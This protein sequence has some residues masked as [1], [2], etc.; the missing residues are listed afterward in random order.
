MFQRLMRRSNYI[1][2]NCNFSF[3]TKG[4]EAF[5]KE[6]FVDKSKS[7]VKKGCHPTISV[8]TDKDWKIKEL[9]KKELEKEGVVSK[10]T[11]WIFR[12]LVGILFFIMV[13]Y[14]QRIV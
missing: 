6:R 2:N 5:I 13:L 10:Q 14:E 7:E 4:F 11:E 9:V 12:G 8:E 1:M 3:Q